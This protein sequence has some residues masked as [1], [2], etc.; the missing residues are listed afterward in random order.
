MCLNLTIK[1]EIKFSTGKSIFLEQIIKEY[2]LEDSFII[3][4]NIFKNI[5][6]FKIFK[7]EIAPLFKY[8]YSYNYGRI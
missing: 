4:K 1:N 7:K 8:N 3:K 2:K 6:N 5:L